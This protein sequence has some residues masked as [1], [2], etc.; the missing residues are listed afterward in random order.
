MAFDLLY[1]L[2]VDSILCAHWTSYHHHHYTS[3]ISAGVRC[4]CHFHQNRNLRLLFLI[5]HCMTNNASSGSESSIEKK[6]YPWLAHLTVFYHSSTKLQTE[7][8]SFIFLRHFS[9]QYCSFQIASMLSGRRRR[10]H[11]SFLFIQVWSLGLV[12]SEGGIHL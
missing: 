1:H 8:T 2:G 11:S 5:Y 6:V 10:R 4:L 7:V 12:R 3:F 9:S